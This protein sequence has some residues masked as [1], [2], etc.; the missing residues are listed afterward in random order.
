MQRLELS[1]QGDLASARDAIGAAALLDLQRLDPSPS[2]QAR[3]GS[4]ERAGFKLGSAERGDIFHHGVAMLGT[5]RQAG[6]DQQR[7]G[8]YAPQLVLFFIYRRGSPAL[9]RLTLYSIN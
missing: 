1:A 4:V 7:W 9:V 6:Q 3:E 5:A 8:R 2:L